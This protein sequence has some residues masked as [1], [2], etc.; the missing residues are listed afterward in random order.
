MPKQGSVV[1]KAKP[2]GISQ[3]EVQK[4]SIS[5]NKERQ[6]M[7]KKFRKDVISFASQG[8][9]N[10]MNVSYTPRSRAEKR[11]VM[12][13]SLVSLGATP[14]KN[15]FINLKELRRIRKKEKKEQ[16]ALK[17]EQI[18]G[19]TASSLSPER[20]L[21]Q[22]TSKVNVNS[23]LQKL[24]QRR[25]NRRGQWAERDNGFAPTVGKFWRDGSLHIRSD[26]IKK[27]SEGQ[28]VMNSEFLPTSTGQD[29][30]KDLSK[31]GSKIGKPF[32]SFKKG[33][34]KRGPKKGIGKRRK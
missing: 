26:D 34:K 15:K 1:A 29:N 30:K 24:N 8:G 7:L 10:K 22:Q 33:S 11:H 21:L 25:G 19:M 16:E 4:S 14:P 31:N 23:E 6:S 12:V 17:A 20:L 18:V 28:I 32:K 2:S 3:S 13:D 27:I 5:S 9:E